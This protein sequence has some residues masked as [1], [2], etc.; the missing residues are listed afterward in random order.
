MAKVAFPKVELGNEEKK[1]VD[2]FRGGNELW[3]LDIGEIT[4]ENLE[5]KNRDQVNMLLQEGWI[6]LHV[7]TLYYRED[8]IWRQRPMGILGK[9]R[10]SP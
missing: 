2:S 5:A 10:N 8:G 6:L 7:Y 9:P 4:G 1:I 3:D